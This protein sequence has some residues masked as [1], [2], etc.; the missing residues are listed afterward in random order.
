MVMIQPSFFRGTKLKTRHFIHGCFWAF[1]I[2]A[3]L[4]WLNAIDVVDHDFEWF[5]GYLWVFSAVGL[6]LPWLLYRGV[7]ALR[8]HGTETSLASVETML[9]S[10]MLLSWV[11]AMGPYRWG[12]GYDSFVHFTASVLGAVAVFILVAAGSQGRAS[13]LTFIGVMIAMTFVFGVA[14]EIFEL[15]GDRIF[16]TA[17]AGE[18]GQPNDTQV[19]LRYDVLGLLAGVVMAL[20]WK[21]PIVA[22]LGLGKNKNS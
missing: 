12:F 3:V 17:M 18:A 16:G 20:W 4:F 8:R 15:G 5:L 1:L 22:R 21:D 13:R 10:A 19:D 2:L 14:N 11:G 9:A 6:L 7:P